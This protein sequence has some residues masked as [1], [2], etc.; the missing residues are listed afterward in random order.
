MIAKK[1]L[2]G[3]FIGLMAG[4]SSICFSQNIRAKNTITYHVISNDTELLGDNQSE[5]KQCVALLNAATDRLRVN[6]PKKDFKKADQDDAIRILA[7]IDSVFTE[8]G[9]L[10]Y[11]N[12]KDIHYDFLTLAFRASY[13]PEEYLFANR[14]RSTYF[15][16]LGKRECKLI[17]CDLYCFIYLGIAEM[18]NLPLSMV[19]LPQHNFIRWYFPDGRFINWE[20]IEGKYHSADSTLSCYGYLNDINRQYYLR[21]WPS[22]EVLSY[23][24]T[25]RGSIFDYNNLYL[26]PKKAKRDYEKA[27]RISSNRAVTFNNLAWLYVV[28]PSFDNEF[29]LQKLLAMMDTAINRLNDRNYYDT[30]AGLYAQAGNFKSAIACLEQG[31]EVENDP[32]DVL[33]AC[34]EHLAWFK[35]GITI[36]EGKRKEQ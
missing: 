33:D 2:I 5:V 17:D 32:D 1:V 12:S 14:Y 3:V 20:A 8:F 10:Y 30:K 18:N 28:N 29:N 11:T 7:T 23:Y 15:R 6:F 4:T 36:R 24:Y 34:K 22:T 25:L 13:D 16:S 19:E 27:I 35:L 31:I 21:P 9:F 26:N